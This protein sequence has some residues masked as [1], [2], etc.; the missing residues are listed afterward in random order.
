MLDHWGKPV[1]T[2]FLF[3]FSQIGLRAAVGG[4]LLLVAG[5]AWLG[6]WLAVK[7]SEGSR[8]LFALLYAAAPVT[9]MAAFGLTPETLFAFLLTASLVLIVER[10]PGWGALVFSLLP[11]VRNEAAFLL[12]V[13]AVYLGRREGW[14]CV[15]L[16]LA[17]TLT[18][19]AAGAAVHGDAFW[20]LTGL[21]YGQA[22]PAYG[23]GPPWSYLVRFPAM[24]GVVASAL[25]VLGAG[26]ALRRE[27]DVRE[28]AALLVALLGAYTLIHSLARWSG[29]GSSLGLSRYFAAVA[30]LVALLAA[31]GA[32][33]GL[34]TM[35]R[36]RRDL[37]PVVAGAV[38]LELLLW[39][40][41]PLQPDPETAVMASVAAE[42]GEHDRPG[43]RILFY[44]PRFAVLYGFDPYDCARSCFLLADPCSPPR[45]GDLVVWD[46]H[47]GAIEGRFLG[48]PVPEATRSLLERRGD[49]RTLGGAPYRVEVLRVIGSE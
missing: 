5:T 11:L 46:S 45:P 30:P 9:F 49:F 2:M 7:L 3:P 43:G 13:V 1:Y 24:F 48:R 37:R 21:P 8:A 41:V 29:F 34:R 26:V 38:L 17:G 44:D 25:A 39:A 36:A 20:L 28:T 10:R 14:R 23:T 15:A 31:T 47:Y 4:Q 18:A 32:K 12:P 16:L 19:A 42:V 40:E 35:H 33:E 22:P 6:G 27:G